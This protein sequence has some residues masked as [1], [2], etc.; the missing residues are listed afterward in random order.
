M[1]RKDVNGEQF[2]ASLAE[3]RKIMKAYFKKSSDLERLSCNESSQNQAIRLQ[4]IQRDKTRVPETSISSQSEASAE[5]PACSSEDQ[6]VEL[7]I[8]NTVVPANNSSALTM[9]STD[10]VS[11]SVSGLKY[12]NDAN[13]VTEVLHQSDIGL[14]KVDERRL[15]NV[16]PA[17]CTLLVKTVATQF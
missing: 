6:N 17:D 14:I 9:A 10:N 16:T 7:E 12:V 4:Q 15:S 3:S 2:N 1:S 13:D 8:R 11:N 5:Q